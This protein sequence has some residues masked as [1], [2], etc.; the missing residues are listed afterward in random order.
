MIDAVLTWTDGTDPKILKKKG[1]Y[2]TV[3]QETK[4]DDIA[5]PQRYIQSGEICY[6]VAS[7]LRFAP[8]VKRIFIVTPDQDPHLEDFLYHN[9]P[10]SRVPIVIIDQDTLFAGYEH[11]LPVFNSLAVETMLWRI[12]G[13]SEEFIYMC[14]DYFFAAPSKYEDLFE[15]GK[16]VLYAKKYP[17][18]AAQLLHRIRKKRAD[19]SKRFTYKDSLMNGAIAAEEKSYFHVQHIPHPLLKSLYEEFFKTHPEA[20]K[21]NIRHRFRNSEQFNVQS[22]GYS[23]AAKNGK[24]VY[25]PRPNVC[26][27]LQPTPKKKNYIQRKLKEISRMKNFRYGCMNDLRNA[28]MEEQKLFWDWISNLLHVD[29]SNLE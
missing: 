19:G 8:Y 26:V 9:F 22:L 3:R 13:L 16:P 27:K 15:N 21:Q 12:P 4:Y 25:R 7:I 14:D 24:L 10:E 18:W 5:G 6:A 20:L 17:V 23:L 2:I 29:F 11:V 1:K 28:P